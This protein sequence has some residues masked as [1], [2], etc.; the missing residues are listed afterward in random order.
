MII[1]HIIQ[2]NKIFK[3]IYAIYKNKLNTLI[4]NPKII[5]IDP[6]HKNIQANIILIIIL[7]KNEKKIK[8][9]KK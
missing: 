5:G 4:K 3:P 8:F 7:L 1:N 9:I 6:I 2:K